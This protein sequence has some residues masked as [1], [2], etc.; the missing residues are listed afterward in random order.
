MPGA[1]AQVREWCS[2]K[3]ITPTFDID[4][5]V[6]INFDEKRLKDVLGQ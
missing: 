4:G 6:V 1:G 5:T 3:L 2:G